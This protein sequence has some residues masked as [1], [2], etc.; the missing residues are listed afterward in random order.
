VAYKA[1]KLRKLRKLNAGA[2]LR[3]LSN[4]GPI[5]FAQFAQKIGAGYTY[6]D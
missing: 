6:E 3:G 4:K 5:Q 1:G 2:G